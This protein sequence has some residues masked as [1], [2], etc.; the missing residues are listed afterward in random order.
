MGIHKK[1]SKYRKGMIIKFITLT[2][3]IYYG[4][5]TLTLDFV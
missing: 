2:Y 4:E 1:F 3:Y 5:N